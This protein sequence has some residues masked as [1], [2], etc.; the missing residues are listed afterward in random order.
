M[1]KKLICPFLLAVGLIVHAQVGINT[2]N[3]ETTF[4]VVGK[5]NDSKH[6][7]GIIPVSYTHLRAHET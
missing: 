2:T 6:Y 5:P 4:D 3:P 1:M 7:D